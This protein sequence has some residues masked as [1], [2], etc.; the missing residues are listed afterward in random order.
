MV[1]L[2]VPYPMMDGTEI[3][4]KAIEQG[5]KI[6]E[7]LKTQGKQASPDTKIVALIAYLQK[8]GKYDVPKIE[9]KLQGTPQGIPFPIKPGLPDKFRSA[10]N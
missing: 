6:V 5:I 8:L 4:T 3:K 1:Q 7:E 10:S 2:G 9:E